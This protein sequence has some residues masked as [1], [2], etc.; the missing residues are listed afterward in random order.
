MSRPTPLRSR[1][2]SGLAL[3]CSGTGEHG[4]QSLDLPLDSFQQRAVEVVVATA[5]MDLLQSTLQCLLAQLAGRFLRL[6]RDLGF[7]LV[8]DLSHSLAGFLQ[9]IRSATA[10][11]PSSVGPT[12]ATGPAVAS[13]VLL[14]VLVPM[15]RARDVLRLALAAHLLATTTQGEVP[16]LLLLSSLA[17]RPPK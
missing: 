16:G 17:Q 5:Q 6:L 1:V 7:G 3:T 4:S 14:V 15:L 2:A 12:R 9:A 8:A 10:T 13:D 11:E